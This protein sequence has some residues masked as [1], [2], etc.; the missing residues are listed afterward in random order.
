MVLGGNGKIVNVTSIAG[1]TPGPY[2]SVYHATKA[3]A[4][5]FTEAIRSEVKDKGILL[6]HYCQELQ[7]PTFLIKLIFLT[8]KLFRKK[9]WLILQM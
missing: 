8:R 5:S 9:K 1:K 7:I 3:F 2:Q 6:P 4:H